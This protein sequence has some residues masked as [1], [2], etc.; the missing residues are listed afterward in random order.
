MAPLKNTPNGIVLVF[1]ISH[2]VLVF[3]LLTLN[4]YKC[5]LRNHCSLIKFALSSPELQQKQGQVTKI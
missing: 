4:K 1:Q 5:R 3:S 2:V